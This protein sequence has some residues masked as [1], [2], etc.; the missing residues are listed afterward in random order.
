MSLFFQNRLYN[1]SI[2]N[3]RSKKNR[4]DERIKALPFQTS[5]YLRG[6]YCQGYKGDIPAAGAGRLTSCVTI[7]TQRVRERRE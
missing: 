6:P 3:R 5:N 1:T 2:L 7:P 4:A